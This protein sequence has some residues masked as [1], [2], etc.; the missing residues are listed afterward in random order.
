MIF[1][2][3]PRRAQCQPAE[4]AAAARVP[5]AWRVQ[6]A[7]KR[8][9]SHTKNGNVAEH[10][11]EPAHTHTHTRGFRLTQKRSQLNTHTHTQHI[12]TQ[13]QPHTKQPH[14]HSYTHAR[15]RTQTHMRSLYA[16]KGV[17]LAWRAQPA[18]KRALSLGLYTILPSLILYGV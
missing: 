16:N 18:R 14:A 15:V 3:N 6:P 8:A 4:S 2:V 5:Q 12:H 17:P 10:G 9:L 13:Q 11:V 1:R 7:R